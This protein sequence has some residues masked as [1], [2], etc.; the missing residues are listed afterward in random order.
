MTETQMRELC[1]KVSELHAGFGYTIAQWLVDNGYKKVS[2]LSSP[3]HKDLLRQIALPIKMHD[4]I[5]VKAFFGYSAFSLEYMY[6]SYFKKERYEKI[7]FSKLC[8]G[9]VIVSTYAGSTTRKNI[10]EAGAKLFTVSELVLNAFSYMGSEE[11]LI[12]TLDRNHL[13]NGE[14]ALLIIDKPHIKNDPSVYAQDLIANKHTLSTNVKA[15]KL[16][17]LTKASSYIAEH[18][19]YDL[20]DWNALLIESPRDFND[21]EGHRKF[22][23]LESKYVNIV[24]GHRVTTD[25]PKQFDNTIYMVGGCLTYGIYCE[26]AHTLPS[27]LQKIL[28]KCKTDKKYRVQNYGH[29]IYGHRV[30][31]ARV[32]AQLELKS[33]DIIILQDHLSRAGALFNKFSFKNFAIPTNK[34]KLWCDADGHGHPTPA[35]YEWQAEQ[36]ANY[37]KQNDF[38]ENSKIAHQYKTKQ[39]PLNGF[40]D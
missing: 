15:I 20:E 26:D 21:E 27:F 24:D 9:D 6:S 13:Q 19:Q 28:N 8:D 32:L 37:L 16:E 22:Y 25:Q 35:M 5:T 17:D 30:D 3:E 14:V 31:I 11:P 1:S 34:G 7:D 10:E 38:F 29:M 23:D 12:R 33:G 40:S 4:Q 18:K 36:L 2:I 39:I